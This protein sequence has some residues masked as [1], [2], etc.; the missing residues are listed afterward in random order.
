MEDRN[1]QVACLQRH[2]AITLAPVERT[3]RMTVE[4]SFRI[5]GRGVV[6]VGTFEGVGHQ[7]DPAVVRIGDLVQQLDHVYFEVP[8]ATDADGRPLVKTA[9]VLGRT[10][11]R[12]PAGAIVEYAG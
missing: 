6:V 3:W 8:R 12:L 7:G 1:F 9:I 4:D 11:D 2:L 5:T 10:V